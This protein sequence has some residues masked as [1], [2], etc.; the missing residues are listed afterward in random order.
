MASLPPTKTQDPTPSHSEA[1]AHNASILAVRGLH[2]EATGN[3]LLNLADLALLNFE[4]P[5]K[6]QQASGD[7]TGL[8]ATTGTNTVNATTTIS[9]TSR[10]PVVTFK[11]FYFFFYGSL[12]VPD[13]LQ[14]VC[15]IEDEDSITLQK[16]ASIQGW[17]YKMWGPYPA[18]VP[19]AAGDKD[20]HVEGTL[21]L[22]EKPEH[23]ARLCKYETE[24]YRMA[25]CN[26]L[27][28]AADGTNAVIENART[29]VFNQSYNLLKD[30]DFSVAKYSENLMSF[31]Y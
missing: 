11:P 13:V 18:L 1:D 28:T 31:W 29:F 15:E 14:S 25:Y 12:Q 10:S 19:A 5:A 8:I 2:T 16:N 3:D 6:I 4:I 20:G 21:W 30:G 26:V 23:V 9:T 22:C 7:D 24:A 27:T 17:T